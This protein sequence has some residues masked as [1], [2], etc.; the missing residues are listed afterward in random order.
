[1][2]A[3]HGGSRAARLS[4]CRSGAQEE[5]MWHM[6]ENGVRKRINGIEREWRLQKHQRYLVTRS[7]IRN[8]TS[9][10]SLRTRS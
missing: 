7:G 5:D 10:V 2:S 1:M 6:A 4:S 9:E 3:E 8:R